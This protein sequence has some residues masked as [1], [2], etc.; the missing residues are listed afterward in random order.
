MK[1]SRKIAGL[2]LILAIAFSTAIMAQRPMKESSDTLWKTRPD[3]NMQQRQWRGGPGG[4]RDSI[5]FERGHRNFMPG[6][7]QGPMQGM[8]QG[9]Q[10]GMGPRGGFGMRGMQQSGWAKEGMMPM[11]PFFMQAEALPSLTDKQRSDIDALRKKQTD[12]MRKL[13]DD[14]TCKMRTL[15]EENRKKIK[16]LLTDEQKKQIESGQFGP[17]MHPQGN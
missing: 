11:S 4:K 5:S 8:G 10:F 15:R 17:G 14:F 6:R 3:R 1:R 2:S 7:F 16:D 9:G 13:F 12:E